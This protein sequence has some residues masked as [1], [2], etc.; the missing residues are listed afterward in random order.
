VPLQARGDGLTIVGRIVLPTTTKRFWECMDAFCGPLAWTNKVQAAEKPLA[1]SGASV[2]SPW[3][4][5]IRQQHYDYALRMP[6]QRKLS[7]NWFSL[8]IAILDKVELVAILP[9]GGGV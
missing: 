7:S 1:T 8:Q 6:A 2:L 9:Q 5:R 3:S 4:G